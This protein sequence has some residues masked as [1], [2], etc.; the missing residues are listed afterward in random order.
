MPRSRQPYKDLQLVRTS[1]LV[2]TLKAASR[3]VIERCATDS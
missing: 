2:A 1:S 3:E